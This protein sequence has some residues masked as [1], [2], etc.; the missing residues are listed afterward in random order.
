ML[1]ELMK[2]K[3]SERDAIVNEN[4]PKNA[5]TAINAIAAASIP[6]PSRASL[7]VTYAPALRHTAQ[8]MDVYETNWMKNLKAA[9]IVSPINHSQSSNQRS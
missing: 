5:A 6:L 9:K 2:Q 3:R 8:Y 4:S 1:V 7:L